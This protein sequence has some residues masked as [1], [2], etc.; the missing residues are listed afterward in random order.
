VQLALLVVA[1]AVVAVLLPRSATARDPAARAQAVSAF[2]ATDWVGSWSLSLAVTALML[3]L[4]LGHA[5]GFASIGATACWVA[6]AVG[7]AVFVRRIR[8]AE[9]PLIPPSYFARR[10]FSLPMVLRCAGN[11]AYFGAFFLAPLV[12]ELGYGFSYTKVGL[13]SIARPLVFAIASPIAGYVAVKV[14]E[15]TTAIAGAAALCG[16]LLL[17]AALHPSTPLAVLIAALALSGLGM[18]VAM[19]ATSAIMAN[20]VR[21]R[22]F[23]VMSAA[24]ILAMQV[25]EVA[26]IQVLATLQ[27]QLMHSRGLTPSS[28]DAALL[29]T[30]RVPFL[31]GAAAAGVALVAALLMRDRRRAVEPVAA[32]REGAVATR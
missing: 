12:M 27:Q 14:G 26:G 6:T 29:A 22:D 11:F 18:G 2:R 13:V 10:N 3:G 28:P 25:G 19:P 17:F 24:Q 32:P 15:R 20:E 23:G 5:I 9:N 7:I 1:M 8:T 21:E 31:V 4:S 16:S 30:F